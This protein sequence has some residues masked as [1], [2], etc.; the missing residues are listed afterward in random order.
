LQIILIII[1]NRDPSWF[2]QARCSASKYG[3]QRN[4]LQTYISL[5]GPLIPGG[6]WSGAAILITTSRGKLIR[7][8]VSLPA[9]KMT[10]LSF[11]WDNYL[12]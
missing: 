7:V 6:E 5:C 3:C 1:F 11:H 8:S 12:V 2:A 10:V 9:Q 4:S